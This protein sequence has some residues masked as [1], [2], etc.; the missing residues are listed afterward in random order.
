MAAT[1]MFPSVGA[2]NHFQGMNEG[3][4]MFNN[5]SCS[6]SGIASAQA[7]A[8]VAPSN[9]K[10]KQSLKLGQ[11]QLAESEE[12]QANLEQDRVS[13]V[14]HKQQG[15]NML[16]SNPILVYRKELIVSDRPRLRRTTSRLHRNTR[17][18]EPDGLVARDGQGGDEADDPQVPNAHRLIPRKHEDRS[19]S[20]Q[21]PGQASADEEDMALQSPP[22]DA[23]AA[24]LVMKI[25]DLLR[26]SK[27]AEL[28]HGPAQR[29]QNSASK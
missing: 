9:H 8:T 1:S 10:Q 26:E 6:G 12:P 19:R 21:R 25:D 15:R 24:P 20:Q 16:I 3:Y 13:Q 18:E 29:S 27:R 5:P 2:I 22:K 23:P 7:S 14:P 11:Q 17:V 28:N 4:N